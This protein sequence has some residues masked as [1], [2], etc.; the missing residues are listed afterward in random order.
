MIVHA[1]I[2]LAPLAKELEAKVSRRLAQ[3]RDRSIGMAGTLNYTVDRGPLR[4]LV[5]DNSLIVQTEVRAHAEACRGAGCYASCEPEGRATATV[6]LHLTPEYRFPPS[7][8][9]FMFTRGCEVRAL[10]GL[11]KVD[12]TPTL[13]AEL[14]PALRR[15]E[16]DIDAKLPSLRPQAEQL[17]SELVKPRSLPLGCLVTSPRGIVLGPV[18]AANDAARVRFG[19]VA[20]PE[21]RA[22][23]GDDPSDANGAAPPLPP[24]AQDPALPPEDDLVVALVG[25]LGAALSAVEGSEP[26][27]T[28]AGRARVVRVTAVAN[29]PGAQADLALRGEVCGDVGVR[30][31]FGWTDDGTALHM[32]SPAI[33]AGDLERVRG[34]AL[35][36]STLGASLAD[37]RIAPALPPEGLKELVPM[38]ATQLSSPTA[39]ASAKVSTV[40]PL[41]A[42][43]HG[44]DLAARVVLRGSVDLRQR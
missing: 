38:L 7:R 39:E 4:L 6:P 36:P 20:Y 32:T 27:A 21:I 8:V 10:G 9:A 1:D 44:A 25:P 34:A 24:L 16:Q 41:D 29:A 37:L 23:C 42:F 18:T 14:A 19:L 2:K 28:G 30:T 22:R 13:R 43:A 31:S 3:E 26:I 40:K 33:V 17:W 15:V 11:I 12:V 5:E 35:E